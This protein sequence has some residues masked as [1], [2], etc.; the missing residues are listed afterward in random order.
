MTKCPHCKELRACIVSGQYG[1][2]LQRKGI[3]VCISCGR[4]HDELLRGRSVWKINEFWRKNKRN[5][6]S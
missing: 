6:R 3:F 4:S 2:G 1:A 5:A